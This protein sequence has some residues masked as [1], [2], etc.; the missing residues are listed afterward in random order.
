M[1]KIKHTKDFRVGICKQKLLILIGHAKEL[2]CQGPKRLG[3]R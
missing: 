1:Q 2:A 3:M